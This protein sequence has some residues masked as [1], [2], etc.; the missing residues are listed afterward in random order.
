MS[1]GCLRAK[2]RN[3]HKNRGRCET[4]G[5][6]SRAKWLR[7]RRSGDSSACWFGTAGVALADRRTSSVLGFE[8][9]S[10]QS[11][12]ILCPSECSIIMCCLFLFP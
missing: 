7:E 3:S 5:V 1:R 9:V 12:S 4:A 2:E 11:F 10:G 6:L 8:G